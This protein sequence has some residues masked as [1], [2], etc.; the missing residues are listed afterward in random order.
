M[1]TSTLRIFFL[2]GVMACFSLLVSHAQPA[3][4]TFVDKNEILIGDQFKL[5]IEASFSPD[6]YKVS[7]PVIP[8]SLAHFE[9]VKRSKIDTLYSNSRLTGFTQTLT[10][11]SFDSGKWILP[12]FL[13]S[14][15][16]VKDDTTHNFFTDS[17][18]VTVSFSTADTTSVLRDIK[19]IR[20]VETINPVWYWIG[21]G[22][23]LIALLIFL[24]WFYRFWKK[25]KTKIPAVSKATAY[26]EAMKQ[27]NEL[28]TYRLS[29]PEDIKTVHTRLSEILKQYLSR[30]QHHP[31]YN[32]TTGDILLLL[33]DQ[34]LDKNLITKAASSLRCGDAVKFAKYIPPSVETESSLLSV[35]EIIQVL[36]Q[37]TNKPLN[38]H[39]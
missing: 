31:Y 4:K 15:G 17:V 24:L 12:S 5:R 29:V 13:V 9:V 27:L 26:D 16:P 19:P 33:G 32:K 14:M 37:Q 11:T 25:N 39:P 7:W 23:L 22:A 1:D 2:T 35:K 34:Q 8:D 18:P 21:A 36:H 28:K 6:E 10:L 30:S 20:E 38:P 3:L